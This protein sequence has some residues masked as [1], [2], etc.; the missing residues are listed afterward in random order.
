MLIDFVDV[1]G[2]STNKHNFDT[3]MDYDDSVRY[4][5]KNINEKPFLHMIPLENCS[6]EAFY[7]VYPRDTHILLEPK[8]IQEPHN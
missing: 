1:G 7:D 4:L 3:L 5:I 6:M 2:G 8:Y